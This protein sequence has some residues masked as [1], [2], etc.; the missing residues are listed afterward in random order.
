MNLYSSFGNLLESWVSEGVVP[1][2][3]GK[4]PDTDSRASFMLSESE[5]LSKPHPSSPLRSE[6]G[7]SGLEMASP[8]SPLPSSHYPGMDTQPP[9]L[10]LPSSHYPGTTT[11]TDSDLVGAGGGEVVVSSSPSTPR[12]SD[13]PLSSPSPPRSP[14]LPLS[15]PC[16]PR[17][18]DLPPSSSSSSSLSLG[19]TEA[20]APL[21]SPEHAVAMHLKLEQALQRTDTDRKLGRQKNTPLP[22]DQ[23]PRKRCDTASLSTES[24]QVVRTGQ[25]SGSLGPGR[26]VGPAEGRQQT[27]ERPKRPQSLYQDRLS[28][29][30]EEEISMGLSPGLGY[31]EKLCRVLEE[32]A[33]LRLQNQRLQMEMD[34]VRAQQFLSQITETHRHDCKVNE[35]N[36]QSPKHKTT[37]ISILPPCQNEDGQGDFRQRSMSD[38]HF[39]SQQRQRTVNMGTR[40]Q[41]LNSDVLLE[42]EDDK[43]QKTKGDTATKDKS[44]KLKISSLKREGFKHSFSK[45]KN[46]SQTHPSI[47]NWVGDL[48][49]RSKTAPVIMDRAVAGHRS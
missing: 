28:V 7:D 21:G 23:A 47:K 11:D 1:D 33:K 43:T 17:S 13:L 5:P 32:M 48:F 31:L 35:K 14:D 40:R 3:A 38:T 46:S 25:R 41:C 37:D 45:E 29:H 15:S 34:S 24:S 19:L 22:G 27:W 2:T 36:E 20:Q 39:L 6:S 18:P 9:V 44:W 8:V 26:K 30:T 10:S 42:Q 16:P 49:K 4:W 12:S